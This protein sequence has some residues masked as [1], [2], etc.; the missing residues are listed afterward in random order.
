MGAHEVLGVLC[1]AQE[2]DADDTASENTIDL[3]QTVPKIGV[4]QH[5]PYLCIRTA[6]APTAVSAD[7]LAIEVQTDADDGSGD[8][9]GSWD[10]QVFSPLVG[11]N[12]AEIDQGDSRLAT[13]GAWIF[14]G[15]LPYDLIQ[16]HLRLMFRNT[17]TVGKF[18][19]DA[20]LEDGPA[21]DFRGS[22]VIK[23]NVGQP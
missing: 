2:I 15:K 19:I 8:P 18:T 10:V 13:A 1:D 17:T 3:A 4:G 5:S 6:V 22:Q 7:T 14:R 20:W 21:S 12:G 16:R 11:A 23:S 9:A